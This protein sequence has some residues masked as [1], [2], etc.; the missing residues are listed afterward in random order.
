VPSVDARRILVVEQHDALRDAMRDLIESWG[1]SVRAASNGRQALAIALSWRPD[2]VCLDLGLPLM[3]AYDVAKRMDAFGE[4]RP[5]LIGV[6]ALA[7]AID[8]Q[9]AQDAGLDA[10]V[11]KPA[12]ESLCDLLGRSA[13]SECRQISLEARR[14]R[15]GHAS[16]SPPYGNR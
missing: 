10:F 11:V 16:A 1:H 7:H 6:S 2:A 12:L 13:P 8:R 3:S 9:R 4:A 5:L 14:E 15:P